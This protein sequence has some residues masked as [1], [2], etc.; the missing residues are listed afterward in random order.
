VDKG[1]PQLDGR[2]NGYISRSME[3]G[4]W[5]EPWSSGWM[6]AL[7]RSG[8][9]LAHEEVIDAP[10]HIALPSVAEVAPPAV[11]TIALCK[12]AER[13]DKSRS[14]ELVDAFTLFLG[15]SLLTLV[16][17]GIR[18]VVRSMCHIEV[19]ADDNGFSSSSSLQ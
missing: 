1:H 2:G 11:M 12:Y 19:P 17:L 9:V 8:E 10:T 6:R 18:E 3:T 14:D 7:V 16:G 4:Q 15:K 5:S 13:I